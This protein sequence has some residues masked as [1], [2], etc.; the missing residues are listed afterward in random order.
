MVSQADY[1]KSNFC[2]RSRGSVLAL[3]EALDHDRIHSK[4]RVDRHGNSFGGKPMTRGALYLMLQNRL[5]RGEIAHKKA[6]YPGEH[7]AIVDTALWEAVQS[8]LL[9]LSRTCL[10]H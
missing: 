9:S 1:V 8:K 6:V 4:S 2:S 10:P 5:Y 3:K 7:G